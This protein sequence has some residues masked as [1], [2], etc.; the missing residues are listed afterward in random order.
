[1]D[2]EDSD[3]DE[4]EEEGFKRGAHIDSDTDGNVNVR[5]KSDPSTLYLVTAESLK[6]YNNYEAAGRINKELLRRKS[7]KESFNS[8]DLAWECLNYYDGRVTL[9]SNKKNKYEI[10]LMNNESEETFEK[11]EAVIE[12]KLKEVEFIR[13]LKG[14]RHRAQFPVFKNSRQSVYD[15]LRKYN[16]VI[17]RKEE[18]ENDNIK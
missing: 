7:L 1:M 8:N 3:S 2:D 10:D 9:Q 11:S 12:K 17:R 15:V 5:M 14:S 16:K 13:I 18:R 4:S 6:Q